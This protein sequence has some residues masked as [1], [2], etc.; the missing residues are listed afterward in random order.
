MSFALLSIVSFII[1]LSVMVLVHEA[2]HFF[3]AKAF[4]V[5]V[6][7]FSIGFP[8]RLFGFKHGDTEYCIGALPF[9]GYVKMAG[10][11]IGSGTGAPTDLTS[12]PRWQRILIAVAGPFANFVLAFG[13][14][15]GLYMMHNEVPVYLSSPAVLDFVPAN[16][17][18]ARAGLQS[19][20]R[21]IR[22]GDSTNPT[23]DVVEQ[24]SA[25]DANST[26]PITVQRVVDGQTRQFSTELYLSTPSRGAAPELSALGLLPVLQNTP[27]TIHDVVPGDPAAKAGLKA[28]DAVVSVDGVAVHGISSIIAVLDQAGNKPAN[29]V[30]QRNGHQF[31]ISVQPIWAHFAGQKPGYRLGFSPNP[32]P[33]RVEQLPLGAAARHS[34][35]YNLRSSGFILDVLHRLF[36]PHAGAVV[37][38]LSGP[39]GIAR[40]T[41]EAAEMPGW[42]PIIQLSALISINLGIMNLLPIPI[43]DGGTILLLVIESTFR[44]NIKQ[45]VLE[46][47]YNVAV[48]MLIL[49]FAFIMVNDI[50]KLSLFSKLKP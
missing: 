47:V 4:G 50:S 30:I 40:M 20:D 41:G 37:Q 24:R 10:E 8:P 49:V 15:T 5:K 16:T 13:L 2:G 22:F 18:A 33:Y 38:Q 6:E 45:E 1:V 31:S 19:G 44:R 32:P 29:L 26:V 27:V 43:L 7:T 14:M 46:R 21:V 39:I 11:A 34:V 17:P 3:V 28:G 25:V 35:D 23:W 12:H 36:T 42:Q 48:V 9:G